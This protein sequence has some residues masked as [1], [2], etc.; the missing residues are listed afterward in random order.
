M[1]LSSNQIYLCGRLFTN[2]TAFIRHNKSYEK[3]KKCLANALRQAE[4]VYQQRSPEFKTTTC[5]QMTYQYLRIQI[6]FK[7]MMVYNS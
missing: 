7:P 4:E 2:T 3:G 5:Q 1:Y 6:Q